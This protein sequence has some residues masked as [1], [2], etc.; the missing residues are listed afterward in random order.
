ME[1]QPHGERT[2]GT[3]MT[4]DHYPHHIKQVHKLL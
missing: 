3:I 2:L 1:R 4:K